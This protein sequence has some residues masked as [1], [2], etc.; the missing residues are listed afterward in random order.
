MSSFFNDFSDLDNQT[1]GEAD[2][3]NHAAVFM[4]GGSVSV[5][6]P[7]M[8]APSAPPYAAAEPQFSQQQLIDMSQFVE[9]ASSSPPQGCQ[10]GGDC[11][12]GF[13]SP[14]RARGPSPPYAEV[15]DEEPL[16]APLQDDRQMPGGGNM[17]QFGFVVGSGGGVSYSSLRNGRVDEF[18]TGCQKE[19]DHMQSIQELQEKFRE[20]RSKHETY[21]QRRNHHSANGNQYKQEK[22]NAKMENVVDLMREILREIREIKEALYENNT[23]EP[24]AGG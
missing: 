18:C 4:L 22:Y 17:G 3:G 19:K 23:S 14:A 9:F 5:D 11:D 15:A 21:R 12:P 8:Y 6:R 24:N 16:A 13:Q 2:N 1:S 7:P 10:P 20:H